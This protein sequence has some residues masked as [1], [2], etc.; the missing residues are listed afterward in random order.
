MKE[1]WEP[2]LKHYPHFDAPLPYAEVM[3][4][5][6]DSERVA[7]NTFF[8]FLLYYDVQEKYGR[9]KPKERP[10][11]Y[12]SRRDSYIYS[13]YRHLLSIKYEDKLKA[14][15][16]DEQVIAYRK[17]P[18]TKSGTGGKCN[19]HFAKDAFQEIKQRGDCFAVALDIS[20]YFDNIDHEKL[21]HLWCELM[22]FEALPPDH[23]A[24][25]RNI[26]NYKQVD[27]D[28]ACTILGYMGEVVI[29]GVK[30]FGFKRDISRESFFKD[31][32]YKQL[33]SVKEFREKIVPEIEKNK[34]G[35]GIPQ[36]SPISDLLANLFLF[37]FDKTMQGYSE[38]HGIYYRRYSDDILLIMPRNE[39]LLLQTIELVKTELSKAGSQL[40]IKDKK[41]TIK[42]FHQDRADLRC[43]P[44]FMKDVDKEDQHMCG[45]FSPN[46]LKIP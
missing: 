7:Q 36:G 28:K 40:C 46:R 31:K 8:P 18:V 3:R 12:A 21:E 43:L 15:N 39:D 37:P 45:T 10:I 32:K 29:D 13:Y 24:V 4:L 25:F 20:S 27:F 5:V 9:N 11:R 26:T 23:K 1:D 42:A 30:K 16:L 6:K 34:E 19:I 14:E 33:C 22:G 38:E 17:I 2:K 35:H 44:Y 41:T